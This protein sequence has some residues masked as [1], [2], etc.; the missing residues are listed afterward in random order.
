MLHCTKNMTFPFGGKYEN[1][2]GWHRDVT[3]AVTMSCCTPSLL[4]RYSKTSAVCSRELRTLLCSAVALSLSFAFCLRFKIPY[5]V[6]GILW[7]QVL[8][9]KIYLSYVKIR[10]ILSP[11]R[12][13]NQHLAFNR[14]LTFCKFTPSRQRIKYVLRWLLFVLYYPME[15][16]SKVSL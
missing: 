12:H 5:P 9:S 8:T 13:K 2:P 7:R 10:A 3:C 6:S 1:E 15:L 16:T 11:E 4:V 14:V